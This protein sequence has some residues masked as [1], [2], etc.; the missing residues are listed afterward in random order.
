MGTV[1]NALE[2]SKGRPYRPVLGEDSVGK[3]YVLRTNGSG[4]LEIVSVGILKEVR[5]SVDID[6]SDDNT[7]DANDVLSAEDCCTTTA[8]YWTFEE[9]VAA[10]GGNGYIVGATLVSEVENQAVQYDLLLFN[11]APAGE[12][13]TNVTNTNPVKA[14]ISKYLGT[15]SFPQSTA[16]G[17]STCT[18]TQAS[19]STVGNL[20]MAF[21]CV[22][23][24]DLYGVLVTRTAY[25][26]DTGQA[27]EIT[28]LVEQY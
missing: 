18:Y 25:T 19:P 12:M 16:R 9:V 6:S 1:G 3:K 23:V 7:I 2:D 8:T 28:L 26:H 15:I 14:D 17:S 20:P 21:Q 4:Q 22:T 27:I 10:N 24:D 13:R 11:A 5:T